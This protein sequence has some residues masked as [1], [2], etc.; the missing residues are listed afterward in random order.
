MPFVRNGDVRIHWCEDNT[1]MPLL[2]LGPIGFDHSLWDPVIPF[3][4]GFRVLRMDTRG[5]G[6]SSTPRGDYTLGQLSS[7]ITCVLNAAGEEKVAICGLSLGGMMAMAF[8]LQEPRR[9]SS[10]ILACT[11]AQ[12]DREFWNLRIESIRGV[13]LVAIADLAMERLFSEKF[14]HDHLH[15]VQTLRA[16]LLRMDPQGYA[17]CGAAIRDMALLEQISRILVPT[18]LVVGESDISTP[19][20]DHG[21]EIQKRVT[22]IEIRSMPTAHMAP[23][24]MPRAFAE[25]VMTFLSET[26]SHKETLHEQ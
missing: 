11:S 22:K 16:Q 9:V 7:D 25:I 10:L 17:G 26:S 23:V 15:Q 6:E 14:R 5:H 12:M 18:L 24:E 3:L 4:S 2:L 19:F 1:G 8:A 21:K 20:N 13:G